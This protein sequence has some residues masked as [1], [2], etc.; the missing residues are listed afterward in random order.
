LSPSDGIVGPIFTFFLVF[1]LHQRQ[2]A[3]VHS[4]SFS[5][6]EWWLYRQTTPSF[7]FLATPFLRPTLFFFLE[8]ICVIH[9]LNN[10]CW[11]IAN[12][13]HIDGHWAVNYET[14]NLPYGI[15]NVVVAR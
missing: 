8:S 14:I 9:A 10:S 2:H 15:W 12:H 7:F 6:I 4:I 1:F 13:A 5:Y 11:S 3:P